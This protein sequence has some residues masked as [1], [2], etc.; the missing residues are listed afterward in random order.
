MS[1]LIV[2]SGLP[3]TGKS[4]LARDLAARTG[5]VW[6]R[7]DSLEQGIRDANVAPEDLADA[8]YRAAAAVAADNLR[9]GLDVIADCVNDWTQTRD[10]W[11]AAGEAAGAEVVEVE[12]VCSDPAEHRRRVETR[13]IDVPGLQAPDWATVSGRDYHPWDRPRILV[14]T[15]GREVEACAAELAAAV[16]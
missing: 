13:R 9:L 11:R 1:R 15:A 6:L 5:A 12:I 4:T 7:I 14:D 16:N 8:G 3:G 2:L 10:F